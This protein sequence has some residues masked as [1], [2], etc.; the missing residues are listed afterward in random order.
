MELQLDD[1]DFLQDF[2]DYVR[3]TKTLPEAET[4]GHHDSESAFIDSH[5]ALGI[6]V[7]LLGSLSLKLLDWA[8]NRAFDHGAATLGVWVRERKAAHSNSQNP[9]DKTTQELLAGFYSQLP[10]DDK[11]VSPEQWQRAAFV[12]A[13]HI[14]NNPQAGD[15]LRSKRK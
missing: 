15:K 6:G 10:T 3:R 11:N 13:Q 14:V 4:Q 7:G 12:L 5:I 9:E 2:A 1:A 8:A